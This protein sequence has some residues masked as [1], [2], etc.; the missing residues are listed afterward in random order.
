MRV[1]RSGALQV[2]EVLVRARR[3]CALPEKLETAQHAQR[4]Q[5]RALA[6]FGPLVSRGRPEFTVARIINDD[7]VS[8]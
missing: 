7:D 6:H 8:R 1:D 4:V 3:V 2:T 5:T